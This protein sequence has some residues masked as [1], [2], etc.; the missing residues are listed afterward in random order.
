[1]TDKKNPLDLIAAAKLPEKSVPIC[2]RGDL[3]SE[4][5]TADAEL[6]QISRTELVAPS[7]AD[8]GR[9]RALA[10]QMEAL[11]EQMLAESVQFRLRAVGRRRWTQLLAE[12]PPRD[13]V[14][15]DRALG[16]NGET[17]FTAIVR[18]CVV[19][20][21]LT[22]AQWAGLLDE[23]LTS[24]QFEALADAAWTLNRKGVDVPFSRAASRVVGS[25]EPE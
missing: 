16:V 14:D 6:M 7:L 11:R 8:G 17:F 9:R 1:M 3:L 18:A 22:E 24:A 20:P 25:T 23:T 4:W 21:V 5:D 10:E 15:S 12:H 13:G 19:E 2:L